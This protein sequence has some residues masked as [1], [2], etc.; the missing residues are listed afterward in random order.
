M[1]KHS[2]LFSISLLL[3]VSFV[4]QGCMKD[5]CKT[6]HT[7][8][9]YQP[10]YMSY[11]DLRASVASELPKDLVNPGKIYIKGNYL[12]I[13]EIDKGIHVIDNT[14]PSSPINIGF[15]NI[16]GNIDMAVMG[17][18]L[19]GDSFIDLVAIDISDPSNV[20]MMKRIENVFPDR[21]YAWGYQFD[22]SQGVVVDWTP[23]LITEEFD[24]GGWYG[25]PWMFEDGGVLTTNS[26]TGG[27][28]ASQGA[29]MTSGIG[30]SMARFTIV[31]DFLYAIDE[32][33]LNLFNITT[34]SDPVFFK[35]VAIGFNIE[36]I[37]PYNNILFIGAQN[38]MYIYDNSDPANPAQLTVYTHISS[39]DP[40]VVE[41]NYAYVTLRSGNACQGFT[42]QLEVVDISNT[43]NPV[44]V[45]TYSMFNPHGL[46]I[47]NGAL[48]I[49]DGTDGL[50][51][52]D[53]SDIHA[54]DQHQLHHFSGV[55][56]YDVIPFNKKLIMVGPDGL[57]QYDYSDINNVYLVS[58]IRKLGM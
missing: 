19:Y 29:G 3:M 18:I 20:K 42:N 25:G 34:P 50:K 30:G 22:P 8:T 24:C 40:V 21:K 11:A 33:N 10:V 44:L 46:G 17:D 14:N 32:R 56:A 45:E 2:A 39:C 23:E 26:T 16:P 9:I 31:N 49:C 43:S 5:K 52:Y 36:T 48:F 28:A 12:F 7:Y 51:I 41:G 54:I 15:I 58:M 13:N 37:F 6:T 35:E 1:K 53:A 47:D 38:G 57:Y 55:T 4:F 27:S